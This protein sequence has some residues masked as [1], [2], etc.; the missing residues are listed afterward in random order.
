[1]YSKTEISQ[2]KTSETVLK[3]SKEL[4]VII[5]GINTRTVP[6]HN[7]DEYLSN[8]KTKSLIYSNDN[9]KKELEAITYSQ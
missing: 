2:K 1:M 5:F 8:V 9:R 4:N 7:F 3:E 6:I